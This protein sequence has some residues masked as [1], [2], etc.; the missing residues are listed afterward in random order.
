MKYKLVFLYLI[1]SVAMVHAQNQ[2]LPHFLSSVAGSWSSYYERSKAEPMQSSKIYDTSR[3]GINDI[4]S[5]TANTF[6]S[7]A[8]GN[9]PL[10]G[11]GSVGWNANARELT[12]TIKDIP[13]TAKV[14][15]NNLINVTKVTGDTLTDILVKRAKSDLI[16]PAIKYVA[17]PRYKYSCI[18]ISN[19]NVDLSMNIFTAL[20]YD[21]TNNTLYNDN[22]YNGFYINFN[23]YNISQTEV[24]DFV[25]Y[26]MFQNNAYPNT[27]LDILVSAHCTPMS[28]SYETSPLK[29]YAPNTLIDG[30]V[31]EDLVLSSMASGIDYDAARS[32]SRI[33]RPIAIKP[34]D[35]LIKG[36]DNEDKTKK[37]FNQ[38]D[39]NDIL[40][41]ILAGVN[42]YGIS[43]ELKKGFIRL[44]QDREII[45]NVIFEFTANRN[46]DFDYSEQTD[47]SPSTPYGE[48]VKAICAQLNS[49]NSPEFIKKYFPHAYKAAILMT[50]LGNAYND[51][52]FKS[53]QYGNTTTNFA[54]YIAT[55]QN[56]TI[57]DQHRF[58]DKIFYLADPSG[59]PIKIKDVIDKGVDPNDKLLSLILK[60]Y[61]Y[62][63]L[64]NSYG[65]RVPYIR[66]T[67]P[68]NLDGF[69]NLWNSLALSDKISELEDEIYRFVYNAEN[70]IVQ[71]P[72]V[73]CYAIGPNVVT[74]LKTVF[75]EY[76]S[77]VTHCEYNGFITL[78]RNNLEQFYN[79]VKA[80]PNNA[81]FFKKPY[82]LDDYIQD[83]FWHEYAHGLD[84]YLYLFGENHGSYHCPESEARAML[85]SIVKSK[86]PYFMIDIL[87]DTVSFSDADHQLGAL[88]ALS[89]LQSFSNGNNNFETA[90]IN[91]S[92]S[93]LQRV[94]S[95]AYRFTHI[96]YGTDIN[97]FDSVTPILP[98]NI[99]DDGERIF[100]EDNYVRK[101]LGL[102]F[103]YTVLP[104]LDNNPSDINRWIDIIAA[105]PS[106]FKEKF[107]EHLIK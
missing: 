93:E 67:S 65:L 64:N 13:L 95:D 86:N 24:V 62:H 97:S 50:V 9:I 21:P 36:I 41:D 106:D 15:G 38:Y 92:V 46:G 35:I 68:E 16:V 70:H 18:K 100:L 28:H 11:L 55:K 4:L 53:M 58:R 63:E 83:I 59:Y 98:V 102:L 5:I 23:K 84:S 57:V 44:Q 94:A 71:T 56:E 78:Y 73:D 31:D 43:L 30:L 80:N 105:W 54:Q 90:Y 25:R 72:R 45:P 20:K 107:K 32:S 8:S 14:D 74:I 29:A 39:I 7:L 88:I 60:Y 87:L 33:E 10:S 101:E 76:H 37:I 48:M 49:Y 99:T 79:S 27:Y 22:D 47:F 52:A 66:R 69:L 42:T 6:T 89:L 12:V 17:E 61:Y 103:N 85:L 2:G 96:I 81:A 104:Y 26:L 34:M 3:N 40:L 1:L 75:S 77:G 19:K 51:N 91:E 82:S